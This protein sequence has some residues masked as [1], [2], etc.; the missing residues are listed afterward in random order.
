[1]SRDALLAAIAAHPEEDAPRLALADWLDEFGDEIDRDHADLIRV[2]IALEGLP[3]GDDA[4]AELAARDDKH[5]VRKFDIRKRLGNPDGVHWEFSRGFPHRVGFD[6]N[7]KR[8]GRLTESDLALL[9]AAMDRVPIRVFAGDI[10]GCG[11]GVKHPR[12]GQSG[13]ELLA[14]WPHLARL[15][16][17]EAASD[18]RLYDDCGDF[19]P[20][21]RALADSPFARNLRRLKLGGW[22]LTPAAFA[23]VLHS[24]NWANL[25]DL[26]VSG[27]D[28]AGADSAV[29]ILTAAPT[30]SRFERLNAAWVDVSGAAIRECLDRGKLRS[31]AFGVAE[32]EPHGVGALLGSAGLAGLRELTITGD[33]HGFDTD[34]SPDGFADCRDV[35]HLRDL[36]ASPQLGKLESLRVNGVALGDAG[37]KVLAGSPVGRSLVELDVRQCGLTGVKALRPLLAEG[38]LRRLSINHNPLSRGDAEELASWP[39]YGRLH[40]LDA[41]FFHSMGN[42]G[43]AALEQSPHRHAW[44]KVW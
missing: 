32:D 43:R 3:P 30:V 23:A 33:D 29:A 22:Q 10:L 35:P 1:M 37:L 31:L 7:D 24:P 28:Y 9:A 40:R 17:L 19:A 41:G 34:E 12:A 18:S 4:W 8:K 42:E 15:T 11:A 21:L 20:G 27:D 13:L 5:M 6:W 38:R 44:L 25:N 39:E 2:Q 26:D 14:A 16:A 36:L